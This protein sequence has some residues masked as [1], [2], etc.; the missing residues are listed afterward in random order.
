MGPAD[1]PGGMTPDRI[2]AQCGIVL[3]SDFGLI[4]TI[5]ADRDPV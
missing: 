3:Q 2:Q 1:S 5:V 4:C